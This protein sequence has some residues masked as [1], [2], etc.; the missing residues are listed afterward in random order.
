[1]CF[2]WDDQDIPRAL[3]VVRIPVEA[4]ILDD[5]GVPIAVL[6]H[7][8]G[9]LAEELEIYRVDGGQIQRSVLSPIDSVTVNDA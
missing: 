3:T 2:T 4:Q 6:L 1:M 8:V 9:G 5:D 7:V